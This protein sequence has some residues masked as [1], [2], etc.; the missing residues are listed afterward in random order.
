MKEDKGIALLLA[1]MGGV[2]ELG[3]FDLIPHKIRKGKKKDNNSL[4]YNPLT[5]CNEKYAEQTKDNR[6]IPYL[7]G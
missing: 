7:S 5:A 3:C 6:Y 2:A 1:Q 4:P